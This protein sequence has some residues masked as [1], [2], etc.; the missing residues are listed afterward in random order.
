MADIVAM[1]IMEGVRQ[2]GFKIPDDLSII[3]FDNINEGAYI[4]PKLTTVEQDMKRKAELAGKYLMDMIES[5]EEI[6]VNEK[7]PV[8]IKERESVRTII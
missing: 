3:G 6:F 5:R 2:C 8:R 7:L 4:T 1:G